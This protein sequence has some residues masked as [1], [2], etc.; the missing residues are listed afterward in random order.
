MTAGANK[1]DDDDGGGRLA[2]DVARAAIA[3]HG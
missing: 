1:G 2:G 3:G